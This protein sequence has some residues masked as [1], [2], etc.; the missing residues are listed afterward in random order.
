MSIYCKY[1]PYGSKIVVLYYVD[2]YLYCYTYKAI[3]KWFLYALGNIFQMNFLGYAH[4]FMSIIT[5]HMKDR[6]ISVDQARY[7]TSIVE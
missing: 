3:V 1:A 6:S 7:A 5:Y 4:W 2:Y